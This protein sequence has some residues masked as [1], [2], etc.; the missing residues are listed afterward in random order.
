MD[1]KFVFENYSVWHSRKF[2]ISHYLVI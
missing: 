2:C 1:R